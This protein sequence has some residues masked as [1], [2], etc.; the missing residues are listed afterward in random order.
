MEWDLYNIVLEGI[1]YK[2]T[3]VLSSQKQIHQKT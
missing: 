2:S 3:Q 1:H